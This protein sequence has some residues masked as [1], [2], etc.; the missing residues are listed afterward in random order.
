MDNFQ[1]A[2][3]MA[4]IKMVQKALEKRNQSFE[5]MAMELMLAGNDKT[6]IAQILAIRENLNQSQQ[7]GLEMILEKLF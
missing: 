4:E 1:K 2:K 7:R 5:Q 6:Q 3:K